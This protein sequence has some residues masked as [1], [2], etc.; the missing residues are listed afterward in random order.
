MPKRKDKGNKLELVMLPYRFKFQ[1][2]FNVPCAE[3]L[4]VIETMCNEILGNYTKKEDQLMT[5][6]FRNQ[7]KQR[8]NRVMGALGFEY[9]NYD[10][11]DEEA[12]GVKKR[13]VVSI[14]KRQAMR[15]IEKDKNK[16]LPKISKVSGETEIPKMIP[17]PSV[18]KK[19]KTVES[20]HSEE[21]KSSPPKHTVE[22]P[23][24]SSIGV[25][26]ILEVVTEPLPFAKL[27]PL[28]SELTSLLQ[29]K[30]KDAREV[31]KAKS[32]RDPSAPEGGNT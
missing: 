2:S 6:A 22:T 18:S 31:V 5:A 27:S 19:R 1:K 21:E 24:T 12:R 30:E 29:S 32:E 4:E 10:R 3:W 13:R 17:K 23:S 7:E 14:L 26:E 9:P 28:G 11:L 25:T 16:K 8:L 15:S 20:N